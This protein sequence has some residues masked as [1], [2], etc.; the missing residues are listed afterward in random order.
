[1]E[2]TGGPGERDDRHREAV[3]AEILRHSVDREGEERCS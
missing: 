1:M 2:E 3:G